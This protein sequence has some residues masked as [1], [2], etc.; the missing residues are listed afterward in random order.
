M[1]STM[2]MASTM[3]ATMVAL[4]VITITIVML[5]IIATMFMVSAVAYQASCEDCDEYDE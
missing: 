5:L 3:T 2:L 4:M 1:V